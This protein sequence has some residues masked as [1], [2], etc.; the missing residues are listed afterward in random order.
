MK[1]HSDYSASTVTQSTTW[2]ILVQRKITD[3]KW[4]GGKI[5]DVLK[6]RQITNVKGSLTNHQMMQ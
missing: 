5:A 2:V 4:N 1:V 3:I 6:F